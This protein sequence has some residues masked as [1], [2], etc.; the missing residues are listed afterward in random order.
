[1]RREKS[2]YHTEANALLNIP[3]QYGFSLTETVILRLSFASKRKA[4]NSQT[5]VL[6]KRT[7]PRGTA[8]VGSCGK[9]QHHWQY[10]PEGVTSTPTLAEQGMEAQQ[11]TY[12]RFFPGPAECVPALYTPDGGGRGGAGK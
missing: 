4:Q 2:V 11:R 3:T 1:M 7:S 10:R 12:L 9:V 5:E 8:E 6:G